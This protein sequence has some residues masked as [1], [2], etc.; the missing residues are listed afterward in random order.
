VRALGIWAAA[1]LV[2]CNIIGQGIFLKARA[3]TCNVGTPTLVMTAWLLAGL[4][5]LCGALTFAELGAMMP[6]SGGPYAFLRRA[7]GPPV[8]F[9][10]GWMMFFLGGP[11]A[12]A[13]LA[14]GGAIFFNLISGGA[15]AAFAYPFQFGG[16]HGIVGGTQLAALVLLAIVALVNLAP[17]R[18]NGEIATALAVI[19]ILMLVV[20]TIGAFA[21]GNGSFS[22]FSMNGGAGPCEGIAAA[23]RGGVA[24]FGAAMIGALYA[25][26][27]WSSL[28]YVAGE[29]ADPARSLP[30]ALV[31]SMLV[32]I[33]VYVGANF[34]YFYVLAPLQ[35]ASTSPASS[36]GLEAL[37]HI[38][39]APARG[40]A[41]ALLF[42]SVLAT[43][44][45]TILTNSRIAYALADDNDLVPWLARVSPRTH[46]PGR[47]VIVGSLLAGVLVMIG[48]FDTLSDFE[49]FSV[50]VFYGLTGLSLFV[51]RRTQPDAPRPFVTWGYPI[52]PA[53]FVAAAIWLLYEA[54]VDAPLRSLLGL[55]IIALALPVYAILRSRLP[56]SSALG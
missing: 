41:T 38:F 30:R 15:L 29:V 18:I 16:L 48:S 25:Y 46:V 54:V 7:F 37:G 56:R 53:A 5:S 12:A 17:V 8:G 10:Y 21:I 28:T 1:A 32:I 34:A 33:A 4:L 42:V 19:K 45:V 24:G 14:A 47:A 55:G 35:I 13:A 3:M 31:L 52:M 9:A 39:G 44:H 50:W 43:L 6:Q 2:V 23:A 11:S 36:V 26:Q 27:G 40:V 22:H 51:L 20:L 49:I